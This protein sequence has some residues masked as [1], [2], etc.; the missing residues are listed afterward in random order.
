MASGFAAAKFPPYTLLD[1]PLLAF[2]P[3]DAGATDIH[4]LRGLVN[5][6]PFT[7]STFGPYTPA[8]RVA[9]VGPAAGWQQRGAL[10]KMLQVGHPPGDRQEYVPAYP[11]FDKLF[12]VPLVAA[13]ATA[14]IKWPDALSQLGSSGAPEAKLFAAMGSALQRLSLVRDQFDVVLVHL[15]DHW[16]P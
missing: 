10:M 6:G 16:G 11:G 7:K 13:A 2:A 3:D 4:P 5:H 9:T 14:H 12:R 8:L 15:P 1:E